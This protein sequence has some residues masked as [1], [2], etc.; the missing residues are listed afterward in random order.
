[1]ECVILYRGDDGRVAALMDD[2][3]IRL[4]PA[5]DEAVRVGL[6]DPVCEFHPWQIVELDDL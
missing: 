5:H 4:F 1:M 3:G 2:A 6:H